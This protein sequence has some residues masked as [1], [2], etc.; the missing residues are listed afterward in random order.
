MRIICNLPDHKLHIG[1]Q[2]PMRLTS[3]RDQLEPMTW[4]IKD[5]EDT[6]VQAL[7]LGI[8]GDQ[9]LVDTIQIGLA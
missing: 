7:V 1:D 8:Q 5:E 3:Q 4:N 6:F 9:V 2:F